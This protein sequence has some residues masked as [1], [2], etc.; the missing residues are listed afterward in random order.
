MYVE[1][2][3]KIAVSTSLG[4]R[5]VKPCV[6]TR[7]KEC[8][9]PMSVEKLLNVPLRSFV[10]S[11]EE[12]ELVKGLD[13]ERVRFRRRRNAKSVVRESNS[14]VARGENDAVISRRENPIA[15]IKE[16]SVCKDLH[17]GVMSI[18]RPAHIG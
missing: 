11:L 4:C 18:I 5:A 16:E 12:F 9:T 15:L 17:G 6:R 1:N 8:P 2:P 14:A 3:V 7:L 10:A 13:I